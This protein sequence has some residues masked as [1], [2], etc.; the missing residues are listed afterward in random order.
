MLGLI[1]LPQAPGDRYLP[2]RAAV[3]V[4]LTAAER[5]RLK[6]MAYGRKTPHQARQRAAVV[7][8]AARGRGNARIADETHLHVDTVRTWRGRFAHGGLPA[9][10]DRK[11]SGRPARFSPVQVAEAKA[12]A[13][14][15]PVESDIPLSRWSCPELAAE[16]TARGASPRPSPR[17]RCAVGCAKTR[18]S[19]ASTSPG[20]SSRTPT[21]GPRPSGSWI[22]TPVPSRASCWARTSTS[23]PPMRRPP[24]RPAVVAIR[25]WRPAKPE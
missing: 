4:V 7:L 11:R 10:A 9:L 21:S 13:C 6:K 25:P 8:L 2:I 16:L 18:S 24:F 17:P 5:H 15:L 19:P 14:Q 22:F 3:A 23:S 20:S 1:G 12:L